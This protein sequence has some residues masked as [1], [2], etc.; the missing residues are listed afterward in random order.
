MLRNNLLNAYAVADMTISDH[1]DW[2]IQ[3][4]KTLY[5]RKPLISTLKS[6]VYTAFT[7]MRIITENKKR[8]KRIKGNEIQQIFLPSYSLSF[9]LIERF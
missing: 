3:S 2:D 4:M 1:E 5:I 9:N 7:T 6:P 8:N